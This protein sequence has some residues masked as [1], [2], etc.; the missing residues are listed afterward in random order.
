MRLR[1]L[2]NGWDSY[3]APAPNEWSVALADKFL[4]LLITEQLYPTSIMASAEGGVGVCFKVR[5]RYAD[6]EFMNSGEVIGVR[7]EGKTQPTVWETD[8]SPNAL[9]ESIKYIREYL[10]T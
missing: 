9:S 10:Q 2:A 4:D 5:D 1:G 8:S 7:Y 3:E 6:L